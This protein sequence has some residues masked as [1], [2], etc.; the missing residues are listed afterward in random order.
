MPVHDAQAL[1]AIAMPDAAATNPVSVAIE[2]GSGPARGATVVRHNGYAADRAPVDQVVAM[3][4]DRV[5]NWCAEGIL[6]L[7]SAP[8]TEQQG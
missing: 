8:G 7:D 6:A 3:D 5:G 4:A 1:A 2:C